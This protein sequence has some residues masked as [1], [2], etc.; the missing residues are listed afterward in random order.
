[1]R[2]DPTSSRAVRFQRAFGAEGEVD[3][4]RHPIGTAAGY[5]KLPD[6]EATYLNV[7]PRIAAGNTS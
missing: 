4:V 7:N 6:H 3:P 5:G 1:V 2:A